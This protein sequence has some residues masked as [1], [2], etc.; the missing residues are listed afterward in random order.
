[1][2]VRL[3]LRSACLL[4][5]GTGFTLPVSAQETPI[6]PNVPIVPASLKKNDVRIA[7][8]ESIFR[9]VPSSLLKFTSTPFNKIVY[10][11]TGMNSLVTHDRDWASVAEKLEKGDYEVAVFLGHE[12]AWAKEKY[13]DF[14][15]M[16][17]SAPLHKTQQAFFIV[18]YDNEAKSIADLKDSKIALP[19]GFVDHSL[20]YFQS[21]VRKCLGDD[22]KLNGVYCPETIEDALNDV[23]NGKASMALTDSA[24]WEYFQN[25]Q[26]GRASNLKVMCSSEVFPAACIAYR[27]GKL[28]PNT[29]D[30]MT[31]GLIGASKNA[32]A[33]ALLRMIKLQGFEPISK[34]YNDELKK[35]AQLYPSDHPVDVKK[36]K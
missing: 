9:N 12:F 24:S 25:N 32:N 22:C 2:I 8:P 3:L 21:Q 13:P 6:K 17:C 28:N 23:I 10:D 19:H 16:V 35:I 27:K 20:L 31:N 7:F 36:L 18:K 1:M 11:T 14:E 29:V 26:P 4:L 15:P 33:L 30:Q 34:T 5:A